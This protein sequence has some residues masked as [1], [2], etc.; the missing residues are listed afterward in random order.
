[1]PLGYPSQGKMIM[2]RFVGIASLLTVCLL[3]FSPSLLADRVVTL[4]DRADSFFD[5][6]FHVTDAD[7]ASIDRHSG[8]FESWALVSNEDHR[9]WLEDVEDHHG[10]A[11]GWHK[12]HHRY[13]DSGWNSGDQDNGDPDDDSGSTGS[14]SSGDAPTVAAPEPSVLVLLSAALAACLLKFL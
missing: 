8:F 9:K 14:I 2:G 12:H 5:N 3:L 13:G 4:P 10:K 11:W 6:S 1:M 7:F